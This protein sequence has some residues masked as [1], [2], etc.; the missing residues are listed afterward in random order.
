MV[1]QALSLSSGTHQWQIAGICGVVG[2]VGNYRKFVGMP[3]STLA[4]TLT[5]YSHF[6]CAH[7]LHY[8]LNVIDILVK[9]TADSAPYLI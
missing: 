6:D 1:L 5:P 3:T 9:Q 8:V 7:S 4:L 2:A